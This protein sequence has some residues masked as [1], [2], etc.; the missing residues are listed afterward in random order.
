MY[1]GTAQ[2]VVYPDAPVGG[3]AVPPDMGT[4]REVA[5]SGLVSVAAAKVMGMRR[6][7]GHQGL[8]VS[9]P[10]DAHVLQF[11][12]SS[13]NRS[14]ALA[15]AAAF[16]DAYV[17]YRNKD[18]TTKLAE[19]ISP[20]T[21]PTEPEAGEPAA[22]HRPRPG[23]RRD[24]RHRFRLRLGPGPWPAPRTPP[25]SP[26]RPD[27]RCSPRSRRSNS[28]S[29][30]SRDRTVDTLTRGLR[31]S[32]GPSDHADDAGQGRLAASHQPVSGRRQD[33]RGRAVGDRDGGHRQGG[34]A[35]RWRPAAPGSAPALRAPA[36]ARADR[37]TG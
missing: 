19:V 6:H 12:Y 16:T 26:G 1:V 21:V 8:S 29:R 17:D 22:D 33:H 24:A 20:A 11:K 27:W 14:Q 3:G 4:E 34:R 5:N 18:R 10:V 32:G 9:V 31:L 7:R 36:D 15:G 30:C 28:A 13:S 35:D 37:R 2:V 23:A 25:T